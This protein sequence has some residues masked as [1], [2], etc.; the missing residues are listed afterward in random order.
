MNERDHQN[1]DRSFESVGKAMA[2]KQERDPA[3][4]HATKI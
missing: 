3:D 2:D 4:H 1:E